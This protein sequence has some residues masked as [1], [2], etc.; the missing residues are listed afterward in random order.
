MRLARVM[1]EEAHLLDGVHQVGTSQGEVLESTHQTP[2][3]APGF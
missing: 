2:C 3:D 1:H